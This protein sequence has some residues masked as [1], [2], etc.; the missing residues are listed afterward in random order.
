M[1]QTTPKVVVTKANMKVE[2]R[3]SRAQSSSSSNSTATAGTVRRLV[4]NVVVDAEPRRIPRRGK[5]IWEIFK[6]FGS[7]TYNSSGVLGLRRSLMTSLCLLFL[8]L[9]LLFLCHNEQMKKLR[10]RRRSGSLV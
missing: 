7:H 9:F 1:L 4:P 8:T 2:R 10:E 5:L 6:D 3:G